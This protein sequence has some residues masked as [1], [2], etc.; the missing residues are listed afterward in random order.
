MRTHAKNSLI[1]SCNQYWENHIRP[2]A[3]KRYRKCVFCK[4]RH[5][6]DVHHVLGRGAY[7][8]FTIHEDLSVGVCRSCHM[9]EKSFNIE[10]RKE[11]LEKCFLAT[12]KYTGAYIISGVWMIDLKFGD[13]FRAIELSG[14][15]DKN[16]DVSFNLCK[17]SSLQVA[18]LFKTY[19]NNTL[20]KQKIVL[21]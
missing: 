11:F 8:L 10:N 6:E 21:N 16:Y 2:I 5:S 12:R 7:G 3:L 13:S 17:L 18:R 14:H 15:N 9:L 4:K 1:S 20:K 19:V